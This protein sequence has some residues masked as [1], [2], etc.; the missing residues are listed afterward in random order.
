[1]SIQRCSFQGWIALLAPLVSNSF[2]FENWRP[3]DR[4]RRCSVERRGEQLD[5]ERGIDPSAGKAQERT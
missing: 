4:L 2:T 1:M 5:P 3:V